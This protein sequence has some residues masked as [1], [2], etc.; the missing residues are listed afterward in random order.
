[1][2]VSE[3]LY[4]KC[5]ICGKLQNA[6][7]NLAEKPFQVN[8]IP[9]C[10]HKFCDNCIEREFSRKRQFSCPKCNSVVMR[11]KVYSGFPFFLL[12]SAV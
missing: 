10:G 11:D 6:V 12:I 4:D 2:D 5:S 9:S 7:S 1:M 8:T 3:D